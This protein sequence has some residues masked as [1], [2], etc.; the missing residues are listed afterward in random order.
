M[1]SNNRFERALDELRKQADISTVTVNRLERMAREYATPEV[2]LQATK[3]ELM[4]MWSKLTPNSPKGLGPNFFEG[5]GR[6]IGLYRSEPAE[7]MMKTDPLSR[8]VSQDYIMKLA[9]TLD[10]FRVP[11][12]P[13]G[14]L[15]DIVDTM[16]IAKTMAAGKAS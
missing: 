6:L 16:E 1:A 14:R 7:V 10:H 11:S 2:F 9:D 15:M 4:A 8:I 5:F 13:L 12:M 3:G